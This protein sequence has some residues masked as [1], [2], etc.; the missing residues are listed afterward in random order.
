MNNTFVNI[1]ILS[2]PL[3]YYYLNVHREWL[4]QDKGVCVRCIVFDLLKLRLE[5]IV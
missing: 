2:P 4:E 3:Q 1:N 5:S